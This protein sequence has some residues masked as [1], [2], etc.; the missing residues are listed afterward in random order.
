MPS[1]SPTTTDEI[2]GPVAPDCFAWHGRLYLG[3]RPT[4]WRLLKVLWQSP[5]R[6]E[7]LGR[8]AGPVFELDRTP[9][10][11]QYAPAASR[12]NAWFR[13]HGLPFTVRAR[14]RHLQLIEHPD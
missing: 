1:P 7:P 9:E 2:D 4:A 8:L 5:I 11:H 14:N 3:L 6:A 10:R 12:A 13:W